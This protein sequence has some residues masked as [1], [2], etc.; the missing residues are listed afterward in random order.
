[1]AGFSFFSGCPVLAG[2]SVS[3]V[4]TGF[5]FLAGCPLLAV[6]SVSTGITLVALWAGNR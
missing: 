2:R 4:S 5:T 6:Y 1:L 3:S